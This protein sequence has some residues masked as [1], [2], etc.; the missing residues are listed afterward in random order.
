MEDGKDV[1]SG[2]RDKARSL[3]ALLR[4]EER[5]QEERTK[6]LL[7]RERLMQVA[8]GSGGI[9]GGGIVAS[10]SIATYSPPSRQSSA[11]GRSNSVSIGID[12]R[13]PSSQP[14]FSGGQSVVHLVSFTLKPLFQHNFWHLICIDT[15]NY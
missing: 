6:A 1:G 8:V 7:A 10:S 13:R 12:P 4:D 3:N 5:L 9:S 15:H 2:V 11:L 14:S